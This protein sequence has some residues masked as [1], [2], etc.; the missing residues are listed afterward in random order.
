M[1]GVFLIRKTYEFAASD[2][3]DPVKFRQLLVDENLPQ[4]FSPLINDETVNKEVAK[5]PPAYLPSF[6]YDAGPRLNQ[7]GYYWFYNW[8]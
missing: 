2:N 8:V 6:I 3:T 4:Q 5:K 7:D 1:R